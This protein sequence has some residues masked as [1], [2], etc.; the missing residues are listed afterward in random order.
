MNRKDLLL[1]DKEIIPILNKLRPRGFNHIRMLGRDFKRDM[2]P[3]LQA[4]L[5]KALE[6]LWKDKPDSK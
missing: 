5:D 2:I 1:T 6:P 3:L 4:Q